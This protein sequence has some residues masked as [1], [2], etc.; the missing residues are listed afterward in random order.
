MSIAKIIKPDSQVIAIA[1]TSTKPR[2]NWLRISNGK[3]VT[4]FKRTS[5]G[6]SSPAKSTQ[7]KMEELYA[8]SKV[9][10]TV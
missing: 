3:C 1:A 4:W 6:F 8:K 9:A 10:V 2:E 7:Q 5:T